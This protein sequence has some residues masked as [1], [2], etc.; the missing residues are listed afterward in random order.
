MGVVALVGGTIHPLIPTEGRSPILAAA[1]TN[2]N[3]KTT[4]GRKFDLSIIPAERQQA[5]EV[6]TKVPK[7]S[8]V[9]REFR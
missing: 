1:S 6:G 3:T 9:V 4:L 8:V 5:L 7:L 2:A